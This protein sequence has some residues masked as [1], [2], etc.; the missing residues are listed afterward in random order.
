MIDFVSRI[1]GYGVKRA[2]E[3]KLNPLNIREHTPAQKRA[4]KGGLNTLGWIDVVAENEVTGNLI[5]G[6]ERIAIAL[7][8]DNAEVPF[9]T[10]H[11]TQEEEYQVLLIY[12][13]IGTMAIADSERIRANLA[14][15]NESDKDV[16]DFLEYLK[17]KEGIIGEPPG[18]D[19]LYE[20]YGDTDQSDF[21]PVIVIN[22][23]YKTFERWAK[24]WDKTFGTNEERVLELLARIPD[25]D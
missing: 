12:D 20:R 7:E 13:E 3:F 17:E 5:D 15:I 2:S 4:L 21:Y 8:N 18:F 23:S 16:I 1:T 10:L 6:H 9:I 24:T 25:N 14:I 22:T 19:A 11:L